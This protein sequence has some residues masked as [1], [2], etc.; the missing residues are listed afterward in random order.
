MD[1]KEF[2]NEIATKSNV[3]YI[4]IYI[5]IFIKASFITFG[6]HQ[7]LCSL[8][9][10]YGTLSL[11]P[12]SLHKKITRRLE[13]LQIRIIISVPLS[14]IKLARITTCCLNIPSSIYIYILYKYIY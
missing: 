1:E 12:G 13:K 11:P 6:H 10:R 9:R 2:E 3:I 14:F 4:Y 8:S 5:Y 7:W